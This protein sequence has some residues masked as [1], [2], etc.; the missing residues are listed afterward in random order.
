M[1]Y[2]PWLLWVVV[3][4]EGA[5]GLAELTWTMTGST[6]LASVASAPSLATITVDPLFGSSAN[7][8][9]IDG[10]F[11]LAVAFAIWWFFL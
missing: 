1:K 10:G 8:N 2:L 5:I 4:Y 7:G 6:I 9:Y 3:I 11:D